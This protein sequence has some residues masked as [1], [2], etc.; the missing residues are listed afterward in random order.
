MSTKNT[1][2][3]MQVH[4]VKFCVKYAQD[5]L[6]TGDFEAVKDYIKKFFFRYKDKVFYFDGITYELY[7]QMDAKKLIPNDLIH[8]KLIPDVETKKFIKEEFSVKDY[9][10]ST[11]FMTNE[12]IPTIDFTKPLTF[13]KTKQI[14]GVEFDEHYLN[15]GKPLNID[16]NVKANRTDEVKKG[17]QKVYD[18]IDIVLCSNNKDSYTFVLNFFACTLA[19]RKLRKCLYMQSKERTGK[20]IIINGLLKRILGDRMF[21]TCSVETLTTYTKP[22][23]G[24]GLINFD[25]LPIE[26]NS[27][28]SIGDKMKSLITEPYFDCRTMHQTSYTQKNTFNIIISTNNNAVTLT[29]TNNKKY[30]ILDIDESRIGDT[31]Y[32]TEMAKIVDNADVRQAFYEDMMARY[33]TLKNWNE[34]EEVLT[35]GIK[36]KIIEALPQFHKYMKERYVLLGRGLNI[37]TNDF[38]DN[39]Y[40]IT[41]DKTTKQ[42]LGKYLSSMNIEPK[43]KAQKASDKQHYIYMASADELYKV[44]KI[45]SWLDENVDLVN[46]ELDDDDDD[47]DELQNG[48][49]KSN[50]SVDIKEEYEKQISHLKRE[51]FLIRCKD[52][53]NRLLNIHQTRKEVIEERNKVIVDETEELE[54]IAGMFDDIDFF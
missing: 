50:Q 6:K 51:L 4:D 24:C 28:K 14:R 37:R 9:L 2:K 12:Y 3:K 18:H 30:V 1:N 45:N 29:M 27:W 41:N 8:T 15:M 35:A 36:T 11:D 33:E 38:F 52:E 34:D 53:Y 13:K 44:F 26:G 10:S 22:F 16:P 32:F 46:N 17:L 23:E 48:V 7:S 19:G 25:E 21:K 5:I 31:K 20:G 54:T 49:D 42:Q 39:Y 43:K 47:D 40:R